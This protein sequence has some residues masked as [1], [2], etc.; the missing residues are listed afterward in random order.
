MEFIPQDDKRLKKYGK[1]VTNVDFSGIIAELEKME[2]PDNVVYFPSVKELEDTPDFEKVRNVFFGET[3]IQI[4]YCNGKNTLLNAVEYH[5]S[6]EINIFATDAVLLLGKREDIEDD[7]T[8]DTSKIEA[9]YFK[10]GSAVELYATT[11]HYAPSTL[12]PAG[13]KVGVVLPKGTNYPLSTDHAPVTEGASNEDG[14]LTATNKWLICHKD[15]KGEEGHFA[16]L[17]GLNINIK[18][19]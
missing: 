6:S 2:A 8:Y 11:L 15:A 14:L 1:L 7:N 3:D 17:K 12:D 4:G 10:K 19:E 13:F 18:E 9:F 16:G 5:R